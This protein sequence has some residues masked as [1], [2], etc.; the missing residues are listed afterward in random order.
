MNRESG[1]IVLPDNWEIQF[2][3]KIQLVR[4]KLRITD[5]LMRTKTNEL[6]KSYVENLNQNL[7]LLNDYESS[8]IFLIINKNKIIESESA[9]NTKAIEC[10]ICISIE[11][12]KLNLE[13]IHKIADSELIIVLFNLI[14][15]CFKSIK[16]QITLE[17]NLI[18][19]NIY[20]RVLKL[21]I[22]IVNLLFVFDLKTV[23]N[24]LNIYGNN[25][26]NNQDWLICLFK[27]LC[28]EKFINFVLDTPNQ[29]QRNNP[30]NNEFIFVNYKECLYKII[31]IFDCYKC[32]SYEHM[33]KL[34]SLITTQSKKTLSHVL[35][36]ILSKL[37]FEDLKLA[38]KINLFLS[39]FVSIKE[40][41][42]LN[43]NFQKYTTN[44][45]ILLLKSTY[46]T[47]LSEKYFICNWFFLKLNF[48]FNNLSKHN[49]TVQFSIDT[50]GIRHDLILRSVEFYIRELCHPLNTKL[51][52]FFIY[53]NNSLIF[54]IEQSSDLP[55]YRIIVTR[56]VIEF[57]LAKNADIEKH[58]K[59][60]RNKYFNL[61]NLVMTDMNR[62]YSNDDI[63]KEELKTY[64]L[65]LAL[66]LSELDDITSFGIIN[67]YISEYNIRNHLINYRQDNLNNITSHRMS[68]N[69]TDQIFKKIFF[70]FYKRNDRIESFINKMRPHIVY[71]NDYE[72][73]DI[74][75]LQNSDYF[76]MLMDKDYQNS[77]LNKFHAYMALKLEI[78]IIYIIWE[79]YKPD[80]WILDFITTTRN[81][82]V[83]KFSDDE[84][85]KDKINDIINESDIR[86]ETRESSIHRF[87]VA[88]DEQ[89]LKKT[90]DVVVFENIPIFKF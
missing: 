37:S 43:L 86:I 13:T 75:Q 29:Y 66:L 34:D 20:L 69:S 62:R 12:T 7:S 83:M 60:N 27:F 82:D 56:I 50:Y 51:N 61:V 42:S 65:V 41:E 22:D 1:L 77:F 38:L 14:S 85:F 46:S 28:K 5:E 3:N 90:L 79:G 10:L 4:E 67:G 35:K 72:T 71:V 52:E 9:Y 49:E 45:I 81:I 88:E 48:N 55:I 19:N 6:F 2:T 54:L 80:N 17:P 68:Q 73:F 21:L 84:N 40:L 15:K 44:F 33:K 26:N 58:F 63:F 30:K 24:K 36:G 89:V 78:Q 70:S 16:K 87:V 25:N 32:S 76:L 18:A 64:C 8:L 57:I 31:N 23:I 53:I 59:E 11:L 39:G 74:M 47:A